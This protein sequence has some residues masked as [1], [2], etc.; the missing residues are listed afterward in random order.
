MLLATHPR[1]LEPAVLLVPPDRDP[2]DRLLRARGVR[3]RRRHPPAVRR[4]DR[5]RA[6]HPDAHDRAG[7]GRQRGLAAR[8]AGGA[9][10]AAFP[11][12][13]AT[14]FSAFYLPLFLVLVGL[15]VRG[16][17]IEY[18][19][20]RRIRPGAP[21]GT[22]SSRSRAACRR[23]SGASRSPTSSRASR[24]TPP[25]PSPATCSTCSSRTRSSAGSRRSRSSRSTVRCS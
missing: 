14:L 9:T 2:L 22:R 21:A 3:L 18:R 24:S 15:I 17:A 23:C 19:N 8:L 12:W 13:Y 25:A 16:V 6:R 1:L 20:K 7:L 10:F 5:G 4:S 11:A